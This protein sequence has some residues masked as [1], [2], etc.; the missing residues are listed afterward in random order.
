MHESAAEMHK[1][2]TNLVRLVENADGIHRVRMSGT[3]AS[4]HYALTVAGG[5]KAMSL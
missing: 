1:A 4:A 3:L 2:L 5:Q